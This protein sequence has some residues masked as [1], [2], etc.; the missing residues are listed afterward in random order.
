MVGEISKIDPPIDIASVIKD[1]AAEIA[2]D[3]YRV[4]QLRVQNEELIAAYRYWNQ[5]TISC[6]R[7]LAKRDI[8]DRAGLI[9][10]EP[11]K[12]SA[13]SGKETLA[14]GYIAVRER[15]REPQPNAIS[16]Y[17]A[18]KWFVKRI[19]SEQSGEVSA[20]TES[21]GHDS[22]IYRA[23]HPL[24]GIQ[25]LVTGVLNQR[26]GYKGEPDVAVGRKH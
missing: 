6:A 15:S 25:R 1:Y 3:W 13:A 17:H 18:R 20:G 19:L 9:R 4:A 23:V 12:S 24:V 2:H 14:G 11:S 5:W 21:A 7:T 8:S 16:E 26:A 22:K 10:G